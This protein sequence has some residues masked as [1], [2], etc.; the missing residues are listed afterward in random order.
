MTRWHITL[1]I[2]I[3]LATAVL[4]WSLW[5]AYTFWAATFGSPWAALGVIVLIEA[6]AL[7]GYAL[8]ILGSASPV[9]LARHALPVVSVAPAAKSLH[10]LAARQV[11][12]GW[13]WAVAIA[14]AGVLALAAW[15]VWAGLEML[16]LDRDARRREQRM[17]TIAR[18][19]SETLHALAL[20]ALMRDALAQ[21]D[22]RTPALLAAR[23]LPPPTA[24]A[25]VPCARCGADVIV[26][27]G[28]LPAAV[29]AATGRYGCAA[30]RQE[31]SND[32]EA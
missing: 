3:V 25:V 11:G 22:A 9:A 14:L 20:I 2:H 18:I 12:D 15:A 30:C 8:H 10:D 17:Q 32:V 19:Q 13:A 29:R 6:G 31:G 27:S 23:D 16:L 7:A 21:V 1:T 4:G 24:Q 28:K 5:G 26:P